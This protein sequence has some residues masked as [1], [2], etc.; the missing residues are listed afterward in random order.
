MKHI[1]LNYRLDVSATVQLIAPGS[2][3]LENEQLKIIRKGCLSPE[4]D[5]VDRFRFC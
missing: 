5:N 2:T 3:K 1:R 4:E